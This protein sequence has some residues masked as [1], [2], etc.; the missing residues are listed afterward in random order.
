MSK[1]P[2]DKNHRRFQ[3]SWFKLFPEL[4]EYSPTKDAAFFLLC[5]LFNKPS[6]RPGSCA[7]IV[8]GFHTWEKVN[9]R[10]N[11]AF[12][13]QVGKD[14]NSLH[15]VTMKKSRDLM[16]QNQHIERVIEKKS[17]Q[18]IENNHLRLKVSCDAIKWLTFQACALRGHDESSNSKNRGNF[19]E[20]IKL[21]SSYN[22]KVESVVQDAIRDEIGDGKF[23]IIIDEARDESRKEQMAIVLRFVDKD[24]Y[25]RERFFDLVHVLDTTALTLKK[26]ISDVLARHNL[27]IKNIRGQGYDGASNMCGKWFGLQALFLSECPYAYYIH[28]FSHRLQLALVMTPREK[29]STISEL[30]QYLVKSRKSTIY[31]L[32]D[33]FVRLVLTL[34]V[35]TATT[36]RAFLA[37]SHVKTKLRNKMGDDFLANSFITH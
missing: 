7:F 2:F 4:L 1:Y 18:K 8:K 35:S 20:L 16:N 34:P 15:K 24:G 9:D 36:E 11:C 37:M 25:V 3:A 5:Y 33:R 26:E 31:P 19:I 27:S 14:P 17:C 22:D 13:C 21:L 6:G 23:C 12:L 28:C 32:I 10:K 29:L 30:C